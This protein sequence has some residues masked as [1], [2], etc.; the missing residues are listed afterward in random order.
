MVTLEYNGQAFSFETHPALF[1]P[2][3]VDAGTLAMLHC[4]DFR[5]GAR[6]V[7]LGCGYGVVGLVAARFVGGGNV[8]LLDCD[9]TA[10]AI[11][12]KNAYINGVS[13]VR[14][15]KSDGFSALDD[16]GYDLILCNP[17]YHADFSVA[18]TFIEKGFNRLAVGGWLVM[19]TKRREW[20]ERK[21]AAVFGGVRVI[22]VNG[23]YVF[24]SEKRGHTYANKCD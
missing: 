8:V 5:E 7:D 3:A 15:L 22:P 19:V 9:D 24:K 1:S 4:I 11:S 2:R 10:I 21:L 6:V 18:K 23:Y 17:P 14:I 20:Y 12:H 16:T 13:G